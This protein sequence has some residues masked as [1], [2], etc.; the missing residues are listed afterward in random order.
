[1]CF[2]LSV[3]LLYKYSNLIWAV[4]FYASLQYVLISL[5]YIL[6][7]FAMSFNFITVFCNCSNNSAIIKK[8]FIIYLAIQFEIIKFELY[9][10][11]L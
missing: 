5:L 11:P 2:N 9:R 3:L 8:Y 1:M 4:T 7:E 10:F 6:R